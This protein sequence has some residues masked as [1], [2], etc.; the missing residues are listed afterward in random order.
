MA[1]I[2][3][4][5]TSTQ[6]LSHGQVLTEPYPMAKARLVAEEMAQAIA[7]ELTDKQLVAQKVNLHIGYDAE[8]MQKAEIRNKYKGPTHTDY[9]GRT[10]PQHANGTISLT[11]PTDVIGKIVEATLTLFD[12]IANPL[13]L[14]RRL[15]L[16]AADVIP[17]SIGR[18]S[19][20]PVQLELFDDS[21]VNHGHT[22]TDRDIRQEKLQKVMLDIKKQFGKNAILNGVSY[23]EGATAR[24][25]NQQIGGHKA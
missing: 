14:I 13:L 16:T 9:Y 12:S 11:S 22:N 8:N 18:S 4:Y 2:K 17:V 7:L 24:E 23:N 1:A 20:M 5:K 19:H 21:N 15:T 6:S 10:V 25:R 3:S